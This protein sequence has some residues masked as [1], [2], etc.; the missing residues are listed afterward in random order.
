MG[1]LER[2]FKGLTD[3]KGFQAFLRVTGVFQ[4]TCPRY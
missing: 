4:K 1:S 3:H 2:Y